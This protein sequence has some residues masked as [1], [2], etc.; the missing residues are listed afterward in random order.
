MP[1]TEFPVLE[2]DIRL[3]EVGDNVFLELEGD[4]WYSCV[5]LSREAITGL[6]EWLAC[7]RQAAE[8]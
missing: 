7:Y 6:H 5:T 4:C 8:F 2:G 3:R 1:M